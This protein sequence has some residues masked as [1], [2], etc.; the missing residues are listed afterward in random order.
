VDVSTGKVLEPPFETVLPLENL[1]PA[2]QGHVTDRET[3]QRITRVIAGAKVFF[4]AHGGLSY[5]GPLQDV[6]L[7][8]VYSDP[9][10]YRPVPEGWTAV[11]FELSGLLVEGLTGSVPLALDAA[12]V[13]GDE[14]LEAVRGLM[15]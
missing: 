5:L 9:A 2:E 12:R 1:S 8:T 10:N 4:S 14:L 15:S 6:P 3:L 11:N 7:V 13:S